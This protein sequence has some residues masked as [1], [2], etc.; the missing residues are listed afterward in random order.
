LKRLPDNS[1][2]AVVTDPPYGL[3]QHSPEDITAALT[4]WVGGKEYLAK[5]KGFMGKTWDSFVPGPELWREVIRVLKPG[6]HCLVFAGSRTDD[7]MGIALR[8]A[9][10]EIRDK[11]MWLYGTG[12]PKSLNIGK[13][14]ESGGGRPEDIRKLAMGD[15]Y[16]PSGRGRVNYDHGG[17]SAMNGAT[18]PVQLTTDAAKQWDGWGTAL[19]PAFEPIIVARKPVSEKT[20]AANVLKH[21]T[22]GINIDACRVETAENLNGGAYAKDGARVAS[23]ALHTGSGMNVPGATARRDFEQPAGR[24]PANVIHDGS[25]EVEA[26]FAV[27]GERTSGAPGVR[28]K[29]HETT[30]MVGRLA[31]TGEVETGY[32]DTGSVS[33]FFYSSKAGKTDRAGSSHPTVKPVSLMRYLVRL[34]TPPGG[35]VLDPFAGSGT[36]GQAAL[37][38]GFSAILMERETDYQKDITRRFEAAVK[39]RADFKFVSVIPVAA[40]LPAP[41]KIFVPDYDDDEDPYDD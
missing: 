30:S 19:K 23:P 3:S 12:F 31:T 22:G 13:A 41:V 7:L 6:G 25:D 40:P 39:D 5:K 28:K 20:V 4:A 18:A 15:D 33:R 36:T 26:A 29:D 16:V 24:W 37:E 17:G 38:E 32:A 10:F 34:V 14:I 11:V 35:V 9:G 27:Y 1:V 21:G 8:M 2:D